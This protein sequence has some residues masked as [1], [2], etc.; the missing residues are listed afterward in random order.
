[1][2]KILN[3]DSDNS[4]RL[5]VLP[6]FQE[7]FSPFET[8]IDEETEKYQKEMKVL[9]KEKKRIVIYCEQVL[10]DA[11][12]EAEKESINHIQTFESKKKHVYRKLDQ[13]KSHDD[14]D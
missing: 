6:K 1:M 10:K 12:R 11:E 2:E 3:E 7:I 9:N 5:M 8:Q 14:N 13:L 4:K